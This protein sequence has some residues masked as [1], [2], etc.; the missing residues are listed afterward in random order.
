ML[1]EASKLTS[2]KAPNFELL[3]DKFLACFKIGRFDNIDSAV[4]IS[5][6]GLSE[7]VQN[8]K[9]ISSAR[10]CLAYFGDDDS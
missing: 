3:G 7:A 1:Q 4:I 6:V 8:C 2:G 9:Y 5:S 10:Q